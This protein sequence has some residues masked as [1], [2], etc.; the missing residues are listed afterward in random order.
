MF[1]WVSKTTYLKN[2]FARTNT[3]KK[4]AEPTEDQSEED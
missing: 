1:R 3:R 2:A 4:L